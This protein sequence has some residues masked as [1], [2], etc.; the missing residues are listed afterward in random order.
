MRKG[1]GKKFRK[2]KFQKQENGENTKG[3]LLYK[4]LMREVTKTTTTRAK[5]ENTSCVC[6]CFQVMRE[7][8]GRTEVHEV[9][10]ISSF[11]YNPYT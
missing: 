1:V 8:K 6:V 9:Q 5:H 7:S 11:V 4:A 2:K 3:V 10:T